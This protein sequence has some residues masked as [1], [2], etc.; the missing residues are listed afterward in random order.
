MVFHGTAWGTIYASVG[1]SSAFQQALASESLAAT[2]NASAAWV[3]AGL[4]VRYIT[5]REI[6]LVLL[7]LFIN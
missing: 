4:E 5:V 1:A 2:Y 3:Y 7:L 6:P